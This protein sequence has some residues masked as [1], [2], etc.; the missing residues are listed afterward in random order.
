MYCTHCGTEA[1]PNAI[2]CSNCG[3]SL[4]ATIAVDTQE[5]MITVINTQGRIKWWPILKPFIEYPSIL[6][7]LGIFLGFLSEQP[8]E[9]YIKA[10][11]S[12]F[13]IGLV[14]APIGALYEYFRQRKKNK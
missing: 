5:S 10:A 11:A 1:Q 9:E 6:I 12:G 13:V 2:F 4:D 3:K 7:F 14:L 8:R